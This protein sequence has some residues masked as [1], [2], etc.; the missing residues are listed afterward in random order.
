MYVLLTNSS[1]K[2]GKEE[3]K[4]NLGSEEEVI[5]FIKGT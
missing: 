1:G 4:V 2:I 3:Q 5:N